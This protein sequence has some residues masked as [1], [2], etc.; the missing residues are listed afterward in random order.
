M[1]EQLEIEDRLIGGHLPDRERLVPH[2]LTIFDRAREIRRTRRG[3]VTVPPL[4]VAAAEP[5]VLRFCMVSESFQPLAQ[6]TFEQIDRLEHRRSRDMCAHERPID[7]E[8][9]LREGRTLP[10]RIGVR[11]QIDS[12]EQHRSR[13][14]V[15]DAGNLVPRVLTL[16][17]AHL[18]PRLHHHI[19][20]IGRQIAHVSVFPSLHHPSHRDAL[21]PLPPRAEGHVTRLVARARAT[22]NGPFRAGTSAP[23]RSWF[24]TAHLDQFARRRPELHELTK[25]QV[26]SCRWSASLEAVGKLMAEEKVGCVVV[27]DAHGQMCGIV[28]DRD[29]AVRGLGAGLPLDTVVEAVMTSD[30][31]WASEDVDVFEAATRM[32]ERGFRR[33]PLRDAQGHVTGILALD[34]L[35]AL[36]T[37]QLD[38]VARTAGS[39]TRGPIGPM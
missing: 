11:S 8:L 15:S 19:V 34:D 26:V 23:S 24:A 1:I 12:D 14:Q 18:T 25:S 16:C 35:L 39:D 36:F 2:E 9:C 20:H 17:C 7:I 5:E 4:V 6:P 3:L 21:G 37:R 33:L 10:G 31:E 38:K 29:L 27:V 13:R 22:A 32:A 28:T 30:V